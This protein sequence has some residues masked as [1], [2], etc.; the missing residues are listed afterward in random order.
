MTR[1]LLIVGLFVTCGFTGCDPKR[2][3]S[4]TTTASKP[5]Q[6]RTQANASKNAPA[7]KAAPQAP[8][9]A[10]RPVFRSGAVPAFKAKVASVYFVS[11]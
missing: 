7:S 10:P 4:K 1:V 9:P 3:T 6:A 8:A 5:E 2:T 11:N